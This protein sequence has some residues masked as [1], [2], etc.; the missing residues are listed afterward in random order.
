MNIFLLCIKAI[1]QRVKF[2]HNNIPAI[3]QNG[4]ISRGKHTNDQL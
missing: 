3:A 1:L 2:P 4:A